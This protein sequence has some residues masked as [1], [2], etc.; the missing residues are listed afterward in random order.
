MDGEDEVGKV[1]PV[2]ILTIAAPTNLA[3]LGSITE[4]PLTAGAPPLLAPPVNGEDA[5]GCHKPVH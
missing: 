5:S 1:R 4:P 2:A 3:A